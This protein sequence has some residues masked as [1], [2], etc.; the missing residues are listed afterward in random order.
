MK[1]ADWSDTLTGEMLVC[2]V[3]ARALYAG[4]DKTW[5]ESL[6]RE[7]VFS[8]VPFAASQPHAASA[9]G[10]LRAW[11]DAPLDVDAL[12][13]DYNHLFVGPAKLLAAPWE[14]VYV[15]RERMLFQRTTLEVKGWYE[16]F[17]LERETAYNEPEDHIGLE[18]GF[19]AHLALLGARERDDERLARLLEAQRTFLAEHPQRWVPNWCRDVEKHA[20]TAFYRGIGRLTRGVMAELDLLFRGTYA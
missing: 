2:G 17:G 13:S 7:Q 18:L 5:L 1:A 14:S 9:L 10:E 11:S 20:R 12:V 6:R 4:P 15:D 19:L 8:D 16:R 3:L